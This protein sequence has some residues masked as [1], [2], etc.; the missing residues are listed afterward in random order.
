MIDYAWLNDWIQPQHLQG[1]AIES[2]KRAFAS[3]PARLLVLKDFLRDE[4]A[5]KLSRFLS[6]EARFKS[7]YGPGRL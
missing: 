4:V 1:A 3:H 5:E 2:Y 7:V 6:Q